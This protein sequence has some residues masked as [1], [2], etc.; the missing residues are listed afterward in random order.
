[1]KKILVLFA[2]LIAIILG[3]IYLRNLP[4]SGGLPFGKTSKV[5]VDETVF[6]VTVA[7]TNEEK[8][9]G[10]SQFAKIDEDR[11]MIFIFDKPDY[12]SFWMKE[13]KF[14]IDII[15][16]NKDKIVT[17]LEK[18]EPPTGSETALQIFNPTSPAD[19]VLEINAGLSEKYNFKLG[20]SVKI[21]L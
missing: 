11:G 6:K 7:K 4:T 13:M 12:Y 8:E 18:I 3:T 1:M 14:P 19:S 20:D 10:L 2:I 5:T 21:E 16:I 15:F 9:V 17:I